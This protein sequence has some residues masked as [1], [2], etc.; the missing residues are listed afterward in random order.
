MVRSPSLSARDEGITFFFN[1]YATEIPE[2]RGEPDIM[3]STVY[4]LLC[5]S[6]SFTNAVSSVGY[7]GLSNVTK[8]PN[9]MIIARRKYAASLQSITRALG[10]LANS[11]LDATLKSVLLLAAYEVNYVTVYSEII[12]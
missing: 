6:E 3:G 8:N 9:H 12:L 7:A 11:D 5:R 10:D 1:H 2:P 4:P